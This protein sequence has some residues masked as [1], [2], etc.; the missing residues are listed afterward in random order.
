MTGSDQCRFELTPQDMAYGQADR[1]EWN[2]GIRAVTCHRETWRG[3]R[4]IWHADVDEKPIDELQ[5]ARTEGGERLDGAILTGVAFEGTISFADCV[6]LG[7]EFDGTTLHGTSFENAKL[8]GASFREAELKNAD[9]TATNLQMAEFSEASFSGVTLSE[10]TLAYADLSACMLEDVDG[11]TIDLTYATLA[12]TTVH[13]AR[14]MDVDFSS[15]DLTRLSM[16]DSTIMETT[17]SNACLEAAEINQSYLLGVTFRG[18]DL[19]KSV[20]D[21]LTIEG[22]TF[23]QSR[24]G[25]SHD[26]EGTFEVLGPT[27]A[28]VGLDASVDPEIEAEPRMGATIRRGTVDSADDSEPETMETTGETTV[29]PIGT[30]DDQVSTLSARPGGG[31]T[32]NGVPA[33]GVEPLDAMKIAKESFYA[34]ESDDSSGLEVRDADPSTVTDD[35]AQ[36]VLQFRTRGPYDGTV[37]TGQS[38]QEGAGV[39]PQQSQAQLGL[40]EMSPGRAAVGSESRN[41]SGDGSDDQVRTGTAASSSEGRFLPQRGSTRRSEAENDADRPPETFS[42]RDRVEDRTETPS[43]PGSGGRVQ[44]SGDGVCLTAIGS[45]DAIVGGSTQPEQESSVSPRDTR[46]VLGIRDGGTTQTMHSE[47]DQNVDTKEED[48]QA[49]SNEHGPVGSDTEEP[50]PASVTVRNCSVVDVEF[51]EA[52]LTGV[53]FDDVTFERTTFDLSNLLKA[54]FVNGGILKGCTFLRSGLRHVRMVDVELRDVDFSEARLQGGRFDGLEGTD[55]EFRAT[56]L[57]NAQFCDVDIST[58]RFDDAMIQGAEFRASDLNG[59]AFPGADLSRATFEE[60][61]LSNAQF[62][63]ATLTD[64]RFRSVELWDADFN[65]AMLREVTF[66]DTDLKGAT[67][68]HATLSDVCFH[69]SNLTRARFLDAELQRATFSERTDLVKVTFDHANLKQAIFRDGI[70]LRMATFVEGTGLYGAT[71]VG[72]DLHR[73]TFGENTALNSVSFEGV[74]LDESTFNE[75][76]IGETTF[77]ESQC[78]GAEFR[79]ADLGSASFPHADLTNAVFSDA[80]LAN[81]DFSSATVTG[82]SLD[83][84]NCRNATFDD[85]DMADVSFDGADLRDATFRSG[86]TL[87]G[88]TFVGTNLTGTDFVDADLSHTDLTNATAIDANFQHANFQHALLTGSDCR[89]A[90]FVNALLYDTVLMGARVNSETTFSASKEGFYD[91][92]G[93]RK[94][95]VYENNRETAHTLEDED[96]LEAAMWVYRRLENL[97]EDNARSEKARDFHISKEEAERRYRR[98]NGEYGTYFVKS[99]I[100]YFTYHGESVKHVL[101][102]SAA[103]MIL[104]A[105]GFSMGGI[106][107]R[108]GVLVINSPAELFAQLGSI[109]VW[110]Y[111]YFSIITFST[112]G[113][114]DLSPAGFWSRLLVGVESLL[115]AI[116]IAMLIYVLGRRI[117]R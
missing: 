117:A 110:T 7:A 4:C 81:V 5:A 25:P 17:F 33:G 60:T 11:Q 108:T 79:G 23:E 8:G 36:S 57:S 34:A 93:H 32:D 52:T 80:N 49:A 88:A 100:R 83:G 26:I 111:L 44:S 64:A 103:V 104:S 61:Q 91:T 106:R 77:R 50:F 14:F 101:G 31:P 28:A 27:D 46:A 38:G 10:A 12:E 30:P 70:D 45:Y 99:I 2:E 82:A 114:G 22:G 24:F 62:H 105:V 69:G 40:E 18:A 42:E 47:S 76:D 85:A 89:R 53:R 15:A 72:A 9:L 75:A 96:A 67:F 84:T 20:L 19:R 97:H 109:D 102:V 41:R 86:T 107:D 78:V 66:R 51:L 87:V 3:D 1:D 68:P 39:P 58:I 54:R 43:R 90:S 112:I 113:Y 37:G 13:G 56:N 16:V 73:A 95:C 116:L 29:M 63:G 21:N 35:L 59:G 98:N 6:L 94:T 92:V 71:F 55:I 115:G 48:R 65:D 74:K